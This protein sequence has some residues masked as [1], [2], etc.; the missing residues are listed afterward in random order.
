MRRHRMLVVAMIAV[1]AFVLGG[2]TSDA[3]TRRTAGAKAPATAKANETKAGLL[4]VNTASKVELTALPGI[5]DAYSQ[6]IIDG[7]PYTG[8]TSSSP[9]RSSRRPLTTR[10]RTRSS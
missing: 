7:R 5:G 4:D 1:V 6:K 8:R 10:S 9:R 2:A 3:Q